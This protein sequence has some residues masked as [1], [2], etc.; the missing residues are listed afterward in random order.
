[1]QKLMMV[2]IPSE[3]DAR[4]EVWLERAGSHLDHPCFH[5]ISYRGGREL[6]RRTVTADEDEAV[7]VGARRLCREVC[8]GLGWA[9]AGMR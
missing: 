7:P 9:V 4:V 2:S 1:M 3:P 8:D 5:A 6:S